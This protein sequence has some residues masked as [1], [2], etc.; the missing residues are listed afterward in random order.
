MQ[1]PHL[2]EMQR[3]MERMSMYKAEL[4]EKTR[5]NHSAWYGMWRW[6][7][8]FGMR[9]YGKRIVKGENK[10]RKASQM[11][12][13]PTWGGSEHRREYQPAS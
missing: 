9:L 13:Y 7:S 4:S 1:R 11:T 12:G 3:W 10:L 2:P 8:L 5:H 6:E